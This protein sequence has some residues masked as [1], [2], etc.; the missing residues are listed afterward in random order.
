[1]VNLTL[2]A[3]RVEQLEHNF[4]KVSSDEK[5]RSL[6]AMYSRHM[7]KYTD[8]QIE[9]AFNEVER[10]FK[11]YP[12][13]AELLE[14]LDYQ[15]TIDRYAEEHKQRKEQLRIKAQNIEEMKEDDIEEMKEL[16]ERTIAAMEAHA[17]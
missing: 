8:S 11:R 12:S 16:V 17:Q 4:S 5:I 2:I 14:A 1:M 13:L 15:A 3:E 6:L 7:G 9:R 10:T